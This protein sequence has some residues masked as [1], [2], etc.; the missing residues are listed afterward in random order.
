MPAELVTLVLLLLAPLAVRGAIVVVARRARRRVWEA[1]DAELSVDPQVAY[2]AARVVVRADGRR[3]ALAGVIRDCLYD[4]DSAAVCR[5]RGCRPP[6]L[7]CDCGF[8]ALKRRANAVALATGGPAGHWAGLRALLTV[9]LSGEV[10]EYERGYRAAFQQVHRVEVPRVCLRCELAGAGARPVMLTASAS[11][12]REAFT[13]PDWRT[14]GTT[15]PAGY[16][17]VRAVC[18]EHRPVAASTI[19]LTPADLAGLLGTE[20][21]WLAARDEQGPASTAA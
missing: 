19:T 2:K 10:L 3:A 16:W 9:E 20:V 12:C 14:P 8:Y 15:L 1:M 11:W 17:P 6:G 13:R 5:P 7:D 18:R 21:Q 4:V